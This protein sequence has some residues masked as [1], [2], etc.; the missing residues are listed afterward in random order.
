M[1]YLYSAFWPFYRFIGFY[2]FSP[3]S[4]YYINKEKKTCDTSNF[5]V[6]KFYKHK[7]VVVFRLPF[8]LSDLRLEPSM[9]NTGVHFTIDLACLDTLDNGHVVF[10]TF[11][12]LLFFPLLFIYLFIFYYFL[13][14]YSCC[15]VVLVLY[16]LAILSIYWVL[17][18]FPLFYLL[19]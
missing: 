15:C 10:F 6:L 7:T 16:F 17:Y 2:I 11:F 8:S 18:F 14:S 13:K 4:T 12:Q 3:S 1:S 19:Y 5:C 9:F